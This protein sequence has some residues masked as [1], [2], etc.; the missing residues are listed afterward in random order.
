[1]PIRMAPSLILRALTFDLCP[2]PRHLTCP[3]KFG[4]FRRLVDRR[5]LEIWGQVK[6]R[7]AGSQIEG[8]VVDEGE[9]G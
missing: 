1:M 4:I 5:G 6:C 2:S 8:V 9:R 3:L 7:N